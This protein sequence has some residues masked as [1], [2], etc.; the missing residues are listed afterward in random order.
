M[1]V[2]VPQNL[3]EFDDFVPFTPITN[4][5]E[6]AKS[7]SAS[8]Q[9]SSTKDKESSKIGPHATWSWAS[10][11]KNALCDSD[12][13]FVRPSV[14]QDITG[15]WFVIVQSSL[16]HQQIPADLCRNPGGV[17]NNVSACGISARCVQKFNTQ[18]LIS[19]DLDKEHDCPSMRLYRFP[20]GCV[21]DH[22]SYY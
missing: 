21:C 5:N 16:Y 18:L 8:N 9:N 6:S 20:S 11:K 14:A 22:A 15:R 17:C 12:R 4:F 19:I 1:Y 13:K 7:S 2:E 3:A 10:K